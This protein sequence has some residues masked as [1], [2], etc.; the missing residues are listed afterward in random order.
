VGQALHQERW[1]NADHPAAYVH[2][3]AKRIARK[4][5]E[6][7]FMA[8]FKKDDWI[9][10]DVEELPIDPLAE[11]EILVNLQAEYKRAGLSDE[12]AGL[13][14]LR[15][16]HNLSYAAAGE[17]L[18]MSAKEIQTYRKQVHRKKPH[19]KKIFKKSS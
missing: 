16:L 17:Q 7:L 13:L 10:I 4:H 5:Y 12:A 8:S 18:N 2:K 6:D 3:V 11:I 14:A 19:L 9:E 1:W 15:T